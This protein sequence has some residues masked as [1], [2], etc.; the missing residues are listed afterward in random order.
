MSTNEE[1]IVNKPKK[2]FIFK[3]KKKI[4]EIWKNVPIEDC[5][6]E[7]SNKGNIRNRRHKI[8]KSYNSCGYR[9]ILLYIN[10]EQKHIQV[11]RLVAM[12]FISNPE[13]KLFVNH[14]DGDRTNNNFENLEWVT[15]SENAQH[16]IDVLGK[17]NKGRSV[18]QFKLN[19]S[20]IKRFDTI[21]E[22][23]T[24]SGATKIYSACAGRQFTSGDF[25]W[26]YEFENEIIDTTNFK[27]IP[28]YE[29]YMASKDG[30]IY[31]KLFRIILKPQ[32]QCEKKNTYM[33]LILSKNGKQ[34]RLGVHVLIANTYIDNPDNK[35][36]VNHINGT[37]NDNR[38]ENLER[39]T[40]K[41]NN[42]HAVI[43]GLI[44]VKAV[45]QYSLTGELIKSYFS[46]TEASKQNV[47]FDKSRIV[48]CCKRKSNSH[49]GF[50]WC[51]KGHDIK[52]RIEI[53]SNRFGKKI[54]V[55]QYDLDEKFIKTFNSMK[56]AFEETDV[57]IASIGL[58]CM[59]KQ[60]TSGGF[61]WKY[62][63][64]RDESEDDSESEDESEDDSESQDESENEC[65]SDNN[66]EI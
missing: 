48:K 28:K 45:D 38:L 41:E 61:I 17:K 32:P 22:A 56:E 26:K 54:S 58:C 1:V 8:I 27:D 64:K 37:K 7:V 20:F 39:T 44:K 65:E 59:K 53:K 13:D 19:G 63:D 14:I 42:I 9:Q 49:K 31:S 3:L 16:S 10:D 47:G 43:N 57:S 34:K 52:N 36:M 15:Q 4:P 23:A 62:A 11:H 50:I 2:R 66:N 25:I 51:Y 35:P 46:I 12:A 33:M 18:L 21:K 24:E 60:D 40:F 55:N 29:N 5:D 6:Y 30:N